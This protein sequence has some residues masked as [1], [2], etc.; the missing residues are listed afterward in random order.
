MKRFLEPRLGFVAILLLALGGCATQPAQVAKSTAPAAGAVLKSLDL[1]PALEERVL[2]LDPKH[3]S[4][5]DVRTTLAAVPAPQLILLHGGM[6]PVHLVMASFADFLIAMGYPESRVRRRDGGHESLYSYSPYEH[7]DEIAGAIAWCYEHDGERPLMIGHSQGGVQAVRILY[8]LS[9]TEA[10]VI[11]I[12]NPIARA[13]E[14]RTT[15]VDPLTGATRPV[16]GLIVPYASAV[17]VGVAALALPNQWSMIARVRDIPNT[18]EDF[19]GYTIGIDIAA[20]TF[21]GARGISE[22]HQNGTAHVRNVILPWWYN[23][24]FVPASRDLAASKAM[25]DWINA[26]VPDHPEQVETLPNE[27][28]VNVW[29]TADVW[30]SIK[31]HWCLEA[32]RLIRAKRAAVAAR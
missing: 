10:P 11:R 26:Y 6:Y 5:E 32:Q 7:S 25:R 29:W 2:A 27:P 23:H 19:T 24:V 22:F 28:N 14:E 3:I 15:F 9:G 18:V 20:G 1:D 30:Y 21:P 8:E 4:G 31:E 16:V 13:P 12:W 17:G